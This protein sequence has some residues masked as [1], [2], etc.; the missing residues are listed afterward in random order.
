MKK[1]G[2]YKKDEDGR[3]QLK[4]SVAMKVLPFD[5]YW[6]AHLIMNTPT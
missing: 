1:K 2:I 4:I 3:D 5:R 6:H